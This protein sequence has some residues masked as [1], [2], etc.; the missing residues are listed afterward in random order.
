MKKILLSPGPILLLWLGVVIGISF[1]EAPV[2][3]TAPMLSRPAAFDVGRVVFTAL[4]RTELVL[5]ALTVALGL[6]SERRRLYWV[7][8]GALALMLGAQTVWLLPELAER[9]EIVIA[10][11]EPPPSVAHAAYASIE[12]TKAVLL[13]W[14]GIYALAG[15]ARRTV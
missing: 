4:N 14:L 7:A 5:F 10:G 8:A 13:A 2:K 15:A 11:G 3:F 9:S 12:V 6:A 1:I